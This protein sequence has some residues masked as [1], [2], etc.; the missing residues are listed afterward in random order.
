MTSPRHRPLAELE[1]G[2][3]EIRR[4][5]TDA[6]TLAALFARP[7]VGLRRMLTDGTLD[8]VEGLIGDNW[9]TRRGRVDPHAQI[10]LMNARAAALIAGEVRQW[11]LAGDQLYVD[12]DLSVDNVPPGTRLTIGNA[13]VEVTA[14]PHNGC[15]KF[16]SRFGG[17]A[18]K[19]VNSPVGKRLHLRGINARVV[20][21]GRLAVGDAV[22][23]AS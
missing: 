23:K 21:A 20:T 5:P 1:A 11:G 7:D 14:E 2:L 8:L 4:S 12:F 10:T 6:G 17:D 13:V 22:R 9:R 16:A 3:D 15:R 18:V 19:F